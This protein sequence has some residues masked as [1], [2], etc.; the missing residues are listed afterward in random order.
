MMQSIDARMHACSDTLE[1]IAAE[2][3]AGGGTAFVSRIEEPNGANFFIYLHVARAS[4]C[5]WQI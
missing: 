5:Y 3:R 1:A 4:R 2:V